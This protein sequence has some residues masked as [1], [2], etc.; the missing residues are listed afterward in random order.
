MMVLDKVRRLVEWL[1][2]EPIC[3][4]C[5]AG[6]LGT[7]DREQADQASRELAGASGFERGRAPC[8]ICRETKSVIRRR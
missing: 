8:A 1:A 6:K 3:D 5:I 7:V 2:P 4:D